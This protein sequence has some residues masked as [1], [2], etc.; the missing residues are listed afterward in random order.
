MSSL[1]CGGS[2]SLGGWKQIGSFLASLVYR[3]IDTGHHLRHLPVHTVATKILQGNLPL[4]TAPGVNDTSPAT[5][6]FCTYKQWHVLYATIGKIASS[7]R[8]SHTMSWNV[9][10]GRRTVRLCVN[11]E[12]MKELVLWLWTTRPCVP[13]NQ[14]AT[15]KQYHP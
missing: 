4:M 3:S 11:Y 14:A 15:T 5:C 6:F 8:H 12:Y 2:P 7:I 1:L 9:W 13:Y 10:L